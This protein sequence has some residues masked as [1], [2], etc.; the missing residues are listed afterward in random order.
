MKKLINLFII[1]FLFQNELCA[2]QFFATHYVVDNLNLRNN[3]SLTASIITTLPKY[4]AIQILEY[5]VNMTIDNITAPWIKITSQTG[6]MGWCFSGYVKQI[7]GNLVNE[8]ANDFSSRKAGTYPT[9][10]SGAKINPP[11]VNNMSSLNEIEKVSGYYI[12]QGPRRFQGRGRKSEILKFSVDNGN[13]YIQEI[14]M[15]NGKQIERNKIQLSFDGRRYRFNDTYL[16][17]DD[18][19]IY[20]VYRENM[21]QDS[22]IDRFNHDWIYNIY[23]FVGRL[24]AP[25]PLKAEHITSDY[26]KRFI[27]NYQYH[28]HKIIASENNTVDIQMLEKETIIITYD[29]NI[30]YLSGEFTYP[31]NFDMNYKNSYLQDESPR[32]TIENFV[33]TTTEEPFYWTFGEGVGYSEERYF[34]YKGDIAFTYEKRGGG[35]YLKYVVF[36]KR[37]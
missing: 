25:I 1:I 28:S 37:I 17:L 11:T 29:R 22:F 15:E 32:K 24:N 23:T 33:E 8:L 12:Q 19:H 35:G 31:Y 26:L 18:G 30:K 14:D 2:D 21:L 36:F 10:L 9:E 5:G 16:D 6:Y 27:G 34:F 4:T 3:S 7:E 13:V 20:I